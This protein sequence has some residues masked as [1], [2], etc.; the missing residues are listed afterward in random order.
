MMS[1]STALRA[2]GRSDLD[3]TWSGKLQALLVDQQ[4]RW[5]RDECPVVEAYLE[6]HTFLRRKVGDALTLLYHEVLLRERRGEQPELAEYERRF[7]QWAS[8]IR[9]HFEIHNA[10]SCT[11]VVPWEAPASLPPSPPGFEILRALGRGGMA[12]VYEARQTALDRHVALKMIVGGEE[13]TAAEKARFRAEAQ[14]VASL[15]HA[16]IVQIHEVIEHQGRLFLALELVD[17]GS[18]AERQAGVPLPASTAVAVLEPLARAM[19]HAHDHGIVHRDLKPANILLASG[20]R[21]PSGEFELPDAA[22]APGSLRPPLAESAPKITDFGLAKWLGKDGHTRTGDFLGTPSYM[23]PEQISDPG[24]QIGPATD[25]YGLGAILYEL[26]TGR[27]PFVGATSWVT[28]QLARTTEPVAPARLQPSCPRDLETITLKCLQKD[29]A[30]RYS[31]AAALAD[32]LQRFREGRP[33]CARPVRWPEHLAKWGRRR[34]GVAGLLAGLALV[35]VL[36]VAGVIWQWQR[37]DGERDVA[38]RVGRLETQARADAEDRLYASQISQAYLDW[39]ASRPLTAERIL[40]ACWERDAQKCQWEW[41]YLKRQCHKHLLSLAGHTKPVNTLVYSLNGKLLAS[42]SGYWNDD[43]PG[44]VKLWDAETGKLLHDFMGP[45]AGVHRVAFNPNGEMLAAACMDGNVYCW[46]IRQPQGP[47]ALPALP[48]HAS[49]YSL[50]FHPKGHSLTAC[51]ADGSVGAWDIATR[52]PLRGFHAH[53]RSVFDIAYSPDGKYLATASRDGTMVVIATDTMRLAYRRLVR[54][55]V[56]RVAFSPNSRLLACLAFDGGVTVWDMEKDCSEVLPFFLGMG[57]ADN[58]AFAPDNEHLACATRNTGVRI[59]NV[60]GQR[61]EFPL[62]PATGVTY[63]LAYSP[64]ACWMATAK[65]DNV[66]RIWDLTA[67]DEPRAFW[68]HDTW[69][70]SM[71]LSPDGKTLALAGGKDWSYGTGRKTIRLFD[72]ASG[73]RGPELAGHASWL[74]SVAFRPDGQ[75]LA[76]GDHDGV[77]ILWDLSTLKSTAILKGHQE[78][79]FAVAYSPDGKTLA[80]ASADKTV[81]LWDVATAAER[82]QLLHRV[83]VLCLAFSSDGR[84][85]ATSGADHAVRIWDASAGRLV[86]ELKGHEARVNSVA[87]QPGTYLLASADEARELRFWDADSGADLTVHGH[88]SSSVASASPQEGDLTPLSER[89]G[90]CVTFSPDGRRLVFSAAAGPVQIWD[91][92]SR[93][94]IVALDESEIVYNV[95]AL[96]SKDGTQ[97]F[98]TDHQRLTI[99]ESTLTPAQERAAAARRAAPVWHRQRALDVIGFRE[100]FGADFHASRVLDAKPDDKA[101]WYARRGAAR[102]A[103]GNAESAAEDH[104]QAIRAATPA[105]DIRSWVLPGTA[106]IWDWRGDALVYLNQWR[107]AEQAFNTAILHEPDNVNLWYYLAIARLGGGNKI[108]YQETCQ[109]MLRRFGAAESAGVGVMVLYALAPLSGGVD[110]DQ[111]LRLGKIAAANAGYNER[112]LGAAYYRAGRYADAIQSFSTAQRHGQ[113]KAWDMLFR[114]MA[115]Q[116]LKQSADARAWLS[117][118]QAWIDK[119]EQVEAIPTEWSETRWAHWKER[120]EVMALRDEAERLTKTAAP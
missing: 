114:A 115:H 111:L 43:Q 87:F 54:S 56:R 69:I 97:L 35:T 12:V 96:F 32:D 2:P 79:V 41:H 27:P 86:H 37:A 102:A 80:T 28:L 50:A 47:V 93:R 118:A 108:G 90:T 1:D 33:I 52:Q 13:A 83:A 88:G 44:E 48:Y 7:P 72:P 38:L 34:P 77:A 105:G 39:S 81:R 71:S 31:S 30:R 82:G 109:A 85:L 29:P 55:D 74:T 75:Q 61:E 57:N 40:D 116:Q 110:T 49:I 58:L 16:N 21:K 65:D 62:G 19:Q 113:P 4:E 94:S 92:L 112:V 68:A 101:L 24:K 14:A 6:R 45:K 76:S 103:L 89:R 8:E 98:T 26:L 9:Q 99:R 63:C 20:G 107:E 17:G 84:Y 3:R 100:W 5:Q 11:P 51:G 22:K 15:K 95:N 104:R 64:D 78:A 73:R 60:R 67:A 66:I 91:A 25:V 59:W 70:T 117:R 106:Y 42:G 23:A 53:T 18:L 46:D 120:V 36:G 119:A 10:L